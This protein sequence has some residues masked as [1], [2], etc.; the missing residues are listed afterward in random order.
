M[1]H[2][3]CVRQPGSPG[4]WGF[5]WEE[6]GAE[7]PRTAAASLSK[8]RAPGAGAG[9]LTVWYECISG[10]RWATEC[11]WAPA[12]ATAGEAVAAAGTELRVNRGP[13]QSERV[14]PEVGS[15]TGSE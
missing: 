8:A 12:S 15:Q 9:S 11:P 14:W 4:A 13:S 1:L 5:S 3:W 6:L 10:S 2:L 7:G